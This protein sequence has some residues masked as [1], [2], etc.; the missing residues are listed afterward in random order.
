L[1]RKHPRQAN[2]ACRGLRIFA[3]YSEKLPHS[4]PQNTNANNVSLQMAAKQPV[5]ADSSAF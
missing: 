3:N 2:D 1:K 5:C 4:F